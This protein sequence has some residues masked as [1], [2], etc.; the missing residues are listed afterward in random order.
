MVNLE[1][2]KKEIYQREKKKLFRKF[3][4]GNILVVLFLSITWSGTRVTER[5]KELLSLYKT[6]HV[7][8]DSVMKSNIELKSFK[9]KDNRIISKL[10]SMSKDTD[11]FEDSFSS[12]D[13]TSYVENQKSIYD[14]IEKIIDNKWDSINSI[15]SGMPLSLAELYGMNDGFGLRKNPIY[16]R[17]IENHEGVDLAAL[18]GSEVFATGNGIVER[19]VKNDRGWGN[20]IIINHLNGY[21]TI[22]AHLDRFNVIL[23]QK[24][25][26]HDIIAY[27]GN[28][29]KS[30]G[31]HLHY[32]I[33]IKNR[34]IDP[35]KFF[36]INPTRILARK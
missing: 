14:N 35:E 21:K 5:E 27:S 15:P 6:E 23:G 13:I 24:V 1:T 17:T 30:T 34:P 8:Y 36:H 11:Y 25:N 20:M 33:L 3:L 26:K 4:F 9:D 16:P 10:L 2:L 7:K 31:P 22:Y 29:G 32:E 28:T 12:N 19:F 18:V